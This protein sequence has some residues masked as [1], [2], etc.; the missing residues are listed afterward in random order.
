M[1][2]IGTDFQGWPVKAYTVEEILRQIGAEESDSVFIIK[3]DNPILKAYPRLLEDDGMA[4]GVNP[5]YVTEVDTEIYDKNIIGIEY[6]EDK[7]SEI[8]YK[9]NPVL[10][11]IKVFNVF[12]D[13]PENRLEDDDQ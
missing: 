11:E 13:V 7:D 9:E 12:R 8:G 5:Q 4:Y 1:I 10:K 3:K 2:Q 6:V